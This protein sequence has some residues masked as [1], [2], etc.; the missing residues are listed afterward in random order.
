[1]R[2]VILIAALLGGCGYQ[3]GKLSQ[4]SFMKDLAGDT[5]TVCL[6][7]QG[8]GIS[9]NF[10]R[11]NITNGEVQCTPQGMVIKSNGLNIPANVTIGQPVTVTPPR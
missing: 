10:S 5:A 2:Y 1:M 6:N 11:T 8:E 7:G 9:L 3:S 4:A